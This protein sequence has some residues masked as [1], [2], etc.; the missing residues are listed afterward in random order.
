MK[1]KTH[2]LMDLAA[3]LAV[4]LP[5]Q[6]APIEAIRIRTLEKVHNAKPAKKHRNWAR[7]ALIAA[8]VAA[9]MTVTTIAGVKTYQITFRQLDERRLTIEMEKPAPQVTQPVTDDQSEDRVIIREEVT[10]YATFD[11]VYLPTVFPGEAAMRVAS[12]FGN[13]YWL[14]GYDW[15]WKI[16]GK[17]QMI[18]RQYRVGTIEYGPH[19]SNLATLS[20]QTGEM[21]MGGITVSYLTTC[22]HGK[23]IGHDLMWTDDKY[24]YE[25]S[26]GTGIP[27]E[28]LEAVVLSLQPMEPETYNA[29]LQEYK[30]VEGRTDRMTLQQVLLPDTVPEGLTFGGNLK[31]DSCIWYMETADG[32]K[33]QF[34]QEDLDCQVRDTPG[35]SGRRWDMQH[36]NYL[37]NAELAGKQ[38]QMLGGDEDEYVWEYFWEQDGNW[39]NLRVDRYVADLL[40]LDIPGLAEQIIVGLTS[41]TAADAKQAMEDLK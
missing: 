30:P 24:H 3:P 34:Y 9:L 38:M 41:M 10:D 15:E 26:Y 7:T 18:F 40:G 39:C 12:A 33:V 32:Y 25:L 13:E 27:L 23:P 8:C 4:E 31:E 19:T 16:D 29:L 21:D 20:F 6:T 36:N 11:H 17:H 35:F 28:D 14:S 37:V 1:R 2:E 22:N 5:Q